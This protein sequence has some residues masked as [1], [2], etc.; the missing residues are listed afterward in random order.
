MHLH[1]KN[2]F[3]L[4]D[5]MYVQSLNSEVFPVLNAAL[6]SYRDLNLQNKITS[7]QDFAIISTLIYN[8]QFT[9]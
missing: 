7:F 6:V 4:I 3:P 1:P 8:M 9:T 5:R 2:V